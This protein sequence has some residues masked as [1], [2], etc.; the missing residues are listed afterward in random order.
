MLS[1]ELGEM[2]APHSTELLCLGATGES[3]GEYDCVGGSRTLQSD[4]IQNWLVIE[5]YLALRLTLQPGQNTD[6]RS[7][8][9]AARPY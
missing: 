7:F 8:A 5:Q 4:G 6:Q 2:H 3:V 1:E 9:A